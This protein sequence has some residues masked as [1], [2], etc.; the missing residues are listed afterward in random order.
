MEIYAPQKYRDEEDQ[1]TNGEYYGC[2]T[3]TY[4]LTMFLGW[5]FYHYPETYTV[6]DVTR[7]QLHYVS[8]NLGSHMAKYFNIS[9]SS[10]RSPDLQ[11][12]VAGND[13]YPWQ[14][15]LTVRSQKL[16]SLS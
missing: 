6:S 3:I 13:K 5:H 7:L 10:T 8:C 1:Y 16:T 15:Y 4:L 12:L 14:K 2:A 9:R 11:E